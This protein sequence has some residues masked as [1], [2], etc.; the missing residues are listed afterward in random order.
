[1]NPSEFIC[2]EDSIEPHLLILDWIVIQECR[3][4]NIE[5]IFENSYKFDVFVQ[6]VKEL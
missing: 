6:K 3:N 2:L 4:A 1:M 5:N